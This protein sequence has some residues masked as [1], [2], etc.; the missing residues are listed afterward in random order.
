MDGP[1]GTLDDCNASRARCV[2]W[3]FTSEVRIH[4]R[5]PSVALRPCWYCPPPAPPINTA[6]TCRQWGVASVVAMCQTKRTH[7]SD[8]ENPVLT[9]VVSCS[10][11]FQASIYRGRG[12]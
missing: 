5:S 3:S 6:W 10:G 2:A 1:V 4:Y 8:K 9:T 11:V 7:V 12:V